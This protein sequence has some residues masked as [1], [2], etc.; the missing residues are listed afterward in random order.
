[1]LAL[2]VVAVIPLM[3]STVRAPPGTPPPVLDRLGHR[4]VRRL[5]HRGRR[6]VLPEVRTVGSVALSRAGYR[7]R[8]S[9]ASVNARSTS[10]RTRGSST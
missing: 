8:T 10:R 7:V 5:R 3:L 1:M 9:T 4:R 2:P 6:L